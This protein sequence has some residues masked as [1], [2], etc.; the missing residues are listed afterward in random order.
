VLFFYAYKQLRCCKYDSL[1]KVG[2]SVCQ[3]LPTAQTAFPAWLQP[4]APSSGR[5]VAYPYRTLF[6]CLLA[7]PGGLKTEFRSA[8]NQALLSKA[9]HCML[10]VYP[11]EGSFEIEPGLP[12]EQSPAPRQKRTSGGIY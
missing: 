2:R 10:A 3:L 6:F 7:S 12:P 8:V 9:L 11:A 5:I 4:A 1:L